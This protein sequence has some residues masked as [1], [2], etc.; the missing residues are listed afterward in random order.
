MAKTYKV[1]YRW[2]MR[3]ARIMALVILHNRLTRRFYGTSKQAAQIKALEYVA[4][5]A[6]GVLVEI[7]S[8][9]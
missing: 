7:A 5:R 1:E 6:D 8:E 2:V 9:M 4:Q 3:G